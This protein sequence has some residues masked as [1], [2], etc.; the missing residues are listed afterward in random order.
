MGWPGHR[1]GLGR[2]GSHLLVP[3]T[4]RAATSLGGWIGSLNSDDHRATL[5]TRPRRPQANALPHASLWAAGPRVVAPC[6]ASLRAALARVTRW[7][8]GA[9]GPC[10]AQRLG[11]RQLDGPCGSQAGSLGC[12]RPLPG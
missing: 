11:A 12:P 8:G 4:P 3:P 5:S 2:K 6:P 9:G 10:W 7:W 1:A